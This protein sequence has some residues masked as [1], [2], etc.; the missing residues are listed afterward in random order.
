[1][2]ST[3]R[4]E[5][6][7]GF[8]QIRAAT[9]SLCSTTAAKVLAREADFSSDYQTV[10]NKL[11]LTDE[12]RVISLFESTFPD[13]G[14]VDTAQ[15][16]SQLENTS[17]YLDTGQV[18]RLKTSLET[19]R[20]I[21]LFFKSC[22]EGQ[23]PNLRKLIEPVT[24]FPE[25]KRRIDLLL[26]RFGEIKDN[27]SDQLQEIRRAI[28]DKESS[29]SRKIS[30]ILRK[31]QQEGI[32]EEDASVTVRDGRMLLP[33]SAANKRKLP[34]FIMDESASGKTLYIEPIEIVE[35][36]NIVKELQFAEQREILR[37]LVAFSDF[38]RPYVPEL[39]ISTAILSEIDFIIAK[40][41]V[42]ISM[43][44]GLPVI[45]TNKELSL[46]NA[47][48]PLLEKALKREGKEIV[49]LALSLNKD[50]RILLISGLNAGGKSVCLK[51]V[52]LLQYMVQCGFLIP[53]SESSEITLFDRIF[54]DIGDEQSLE[55]D[56]STYSSHL[57][58]MREILAEASENSLILI[59]EF[60]AGTEPT[61]GGAIAEAILAEVEKR[62]CFGVITTHY[63]NLKFFAS[64]S[65][66]V[67]N[68]GMQFDVQNIKPLFKLETGTPGS[69]FAFELARKI[70]LPAE[71]VKIAEE[72]A[73]NDFVDMERHLKKIARN[74]RAWEE[75]LA[76]IKSTDRTL[77]TI[78]DKYQKELSEIQQ[79]RKKIISDAREEASKLLSETNKKIESTIKEIRE[80]QAQK[81]KTI[82]V[83]KE[84]ANFGKTLEI[85]DESVQD[86]NI[87][88]KMEQLIKR[89]ERREEK[90]REKKTEVKPKNV[91]PV[92]DNGL[93]RVGDK[94]RIKGG[95]LVGEVIKCEGK[96]FSLAI[97]S[98]ISRLPVERV[99]KISGNEY[100]Q[101]VKSG[102]VK[103]FSVVE[104]EDISKRRLEFKPVID[105]R[106]ER[107]EQ[108]IEIVTRFV[109]DAVMVGIGEV[110]ILHGKGNGIL[111][112]EIRKYLKTIGGVQ[113][114]RDEVLQMGGSGIT[115]VKLD[116]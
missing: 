105:I 102:A 95:D 7:L 28:K 81:E 103:K 30:A 1:M 45:S 12:M 73:G 89:K 86:D 55:N 34:G 116:D 25:I 84:L 74:R 14:F 104:S 54:I 36:N 15:F 13:S 109:D 3:E 71:V 78:T 114:F 21:V 2:I 115:V 110:K 70:G 24:L 75:R 90:K 92:T 23:Y 60:G 26:D 8:H 79:L 96:T 113:S 43:G 87:A 44:A 42:G 111:R 67:L 51:T 99:E 11:N 108:A 49:P 112:E 68:G 16:I 37:I 40:A 69:S 98:V 17:Y 38:L 80:S 20:Q 100:A 63:S 48:H 10:I 91:T 33:V 6:K 5:N 66:G 82:E 4:V 46:R 77:E 65:K 18:S 39:L 53:A 47:R 59:D 56:L 22:K 106:G 27:A 62:G 58:N 72:K 107:L 61:A 19:I 50:K 35:L 57:T 88:R 41:R 93:L 9:E 85:A 64:S 97:G 94:V 101:I 83:R 52:G 29:I 31:A 76:K 32:I